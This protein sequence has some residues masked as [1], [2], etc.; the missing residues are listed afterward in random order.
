MNRSKKILFGFILM[1]LT[2]SV[3]INVMLYLTSEE[4]NN[5]ECLEIEETLIEEETSVEEESLYSNEVIL[6]ELT[7]ISYI[8]EDGNESVVTVDYIYFD[9][10]TNYARLLNEKYK[11]MIEYYLN[12]NKVASEEINLQEDS[13][14]YEGELEYYTI[15]NIDYTEYEK[16]GSVLIY[17]EGGNKSTSWNITYTE[18]IDLSTGMKISNMELFSLFDLDDTTDDGEDDLW[19]TI[20]DNLSALTS[21]GNFDYDNMEISE[22]KE[23]Y[24]LFINSDYSLELHQTYGQSDI[25]FVFE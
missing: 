11:E 2:V 18:N 22:T 7:G 6:S 16:I 9:Y 19:I 25:Y 10:D 12:L 23:G 14:V 5:E 15:V 13:T 20:R 21:D 8:D 3:G 17:I 1:L 4:I 24:K